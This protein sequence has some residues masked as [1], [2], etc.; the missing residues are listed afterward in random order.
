MP[1]VFIRVSILRANALTFLAAF[2]SCWLDPLGQSLVRRSSVDPLRASDEDDAEEDGEA[3]KEAKTGSGGVVS[4]VVDAVG[5]RGGCGE[6]SEQP[7]EPAESGEHRP[8]VE[9]AVVL[10]LVLRVRG[11]AVL[12]GDDASTVM[13]GDRWTTAAISTRLADT[14]VALTTGDAEHWVLGYSSPGWAG[15]RGAG[16]P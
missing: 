10:V 16:V 14:G 2:R 9:A 6:D 13:R 7:S 1:T 12:K 3:A 5:L 15:L 11:R 8:D 4:L